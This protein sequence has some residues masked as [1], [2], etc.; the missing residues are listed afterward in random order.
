MPQDMTQ[1][2]LIIINEQSGY[3]RAVHYLKSKQNYLCRFCKKKINNGDAFVSR[4]G[5]SRKYYHIQCAQRL[6]IIIT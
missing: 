3:S 1:T 4:G 2:T 6:N 5:H